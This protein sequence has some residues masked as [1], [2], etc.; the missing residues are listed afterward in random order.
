MSQRKKN[1]TG[2]QSLVSKYFLKY[3]IKMKTCYRQQ[4]YLI[5]LFTKYA[6]YIK[7]IKDN[8][9]LSFKRTDLTIAHYQTVYKFE[10]FCM[11]SQKNF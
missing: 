3:C 7:V 6:A 8:F 10:R 9:T 11:K 2:I 1:R 5:V 4:V